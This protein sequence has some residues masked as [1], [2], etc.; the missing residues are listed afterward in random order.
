M[1]QPLVRTRYTASNGAKPR[2][3]HDRARQSSPTHSRPR[4]R[5]SVWR[6]HALDSSNLSFHAGDLLRRRGV[7]E[8]ID[9][10]P[11]NAGGTHQ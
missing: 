8:S 4:R 1:W 6:V 9:S 2:C 10:T 7:E 11:N 5:V 3:T